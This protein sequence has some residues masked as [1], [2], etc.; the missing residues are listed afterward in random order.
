MRENRRVAFR[1]D[2]SFIKVGL[3]RSWERASMAW[4]RSSV[5][6]RPGPPILE[7]AKNRVSARAWGRIARCAIAYSTK[8][9]ERGSGRNHRRRPPERS[10]TWDLADEVGIS[11]SVLVE[12]FTRYLSEPPMTYLTPWRLQLAARSLETTS[13]GVAEIAADVGY[14]S[15]AAFNRAFKREFGCPHGKYRRDHRKSDERELPGARARAQF[16]GRK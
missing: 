1:R 5:R 13:R 14:E 10:C 9:V 16:A 3:W 11:R 4:K 15:E 6:S 7:Q 2:P 12:R 8:R